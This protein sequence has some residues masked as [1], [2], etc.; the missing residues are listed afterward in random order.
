MDKLIPHTS[1]EW[2]FQGSHLFCFPCHVL[3]SAKLST[4][5]SLLGQLLKMWARQFK[6]IT[7]ADISYCNLNDHDASVVQQCREEI[8]VKEEVRWESK[9]YL[10][11]PIIKCICSY[12][13]NKKLLKEK[14]GKLKMI[15]A[16]VD[17]A[18][19]YF[20]L[21]AKICWV[22]WSYCAYSCCSIK[23]N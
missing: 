8:S 1:S 15:T 2:Y 12:S 5:H 18:P 23:N 20:N 6:C 14:K 16:H 11:W 7:K 13:K 4:F 10:F 3:L 17:D 9:T 21:L 19:G 22:L